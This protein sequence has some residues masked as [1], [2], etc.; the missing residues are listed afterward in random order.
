MNLTH[1]LH[2]IRHYNK[3]GLPTGHLLFHGMVLRNEENLTFTL[4]VLPLH[5]SC[6]TSDLHLG[7][8]HTNLSQPGH[9]LSWG[10]LSVP[11]STQSNAQ[12]IPWSKSWLLCPPVLRVHWTRSASHNNKLCI[13]TPSWYKSLNNLCAINQSHGLSCHIIF[14]CILSIHLS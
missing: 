11:Q 4:M 12:R 14:S 3:W 5:V 10:F 2:L 6:I 9:Q 8:V 1:G 7:C 13:T